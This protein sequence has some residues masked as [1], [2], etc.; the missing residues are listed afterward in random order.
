MYFLDRERGRD[1]SNI[2]RTKTGFT[3]PLQKDRKGNFKIRSGELVRVC[4]TSDFFL[5]EADMWRDE[6]WEIMKRRC[7]V[8]FFILTKRPHRVE[9]CLPQGWGEG[10]E[11][12]QTDQK[13]RS[14][15]DGL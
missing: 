8:K 1:G 5:D 3:Y 13:I 15:R 11:N 4:M 14:E 9:K 7:D 6:A 10:W 12:I 2:Y